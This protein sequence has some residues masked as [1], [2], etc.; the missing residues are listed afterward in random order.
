MGVLFSQNKEVMEEHLV[1]KQIKQPMRRENPILPPLPTQHLK[2]PKFQTQETEV[3]QILQQQP[4]LPKQNSV[5]LQQNSSRSNIVS[6]HVPNTLP[7]SRKPSKVTH[8]DRVENISV[9]F[10]PVN[11]IKVVIN[12]NDEFYM[13]DVQL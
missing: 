11:K 9:I 5:N 3:T 2:N 12:K 7:L 1:S 4:A 13:N 8:M 10:L 6:N